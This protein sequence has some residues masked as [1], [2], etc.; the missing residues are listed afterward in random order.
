MDPDQLSREDILELQNLTLHAQIASMEKEQLI[1]KVQAQLS[2]CDKK[3]VDIRKS[4]IEFQKKVTDKYGIN[5]ETQK[6]EMATGKVHP[7]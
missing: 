7:V 5:F 1:L 4:I 6:I 2:E 3:L